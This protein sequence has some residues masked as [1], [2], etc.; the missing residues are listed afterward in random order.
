MTITDFTT[1][2]TTSLQAVVEDLY[3]D[4]HKG[5]RAELFAVTERAGSIDPAD[6]GD[7]NELCAH[8]QRVAW[9]LALDADGFEDESLDQFVD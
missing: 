1:V 7:R 6:R 4:I 5:I 3:R 9:L 8:V 2:P